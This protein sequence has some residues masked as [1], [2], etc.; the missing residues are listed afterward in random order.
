MFFS[1]FI[2][3]DNYTLLFSDLIEDSYYNFATDLQEEP[4]AIKEPLKPEFDQRD[5]NLAFYLPEFSPYFGEERALPE[6]FS[7]W[8]SDSW[9]VL[10]NEKFLRDYEQPSNLSLRVVGEEEKELFCEVFHQAYSGGPDDP[11]GELPAYYKNSLLQSFS[12][13]LCN[14]EKLYLLAEVNGEPAGMGIVVFDE[15][16]A[17]IYALGT[18]RDFRKQGVGT[19]ITKFLV[20]KALDNNS[21]KI[22][23]QT[24]EGS[25]VENWYESLGFERAFLARYYVE[26]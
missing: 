25:K 26:D 10:T 16:I 23:L 4:K 9:L 18:K 21:K 12:Y 6:N 5:R 14:Y 2:Q 22:M 15:R 19:S 11:Y 20:N 24:E 7:K 13:S 17:G 3:R 8:A 1:E